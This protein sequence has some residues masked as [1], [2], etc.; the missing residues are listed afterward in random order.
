MRTCQ[1]VKVRVLV[2][3]DEASLREGLVDLLEGDGHRV[4][5]TADGR[6]AVEAL[7]GAGYAWRAER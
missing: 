2:V 7:D 3:E 4:T 1:N 5:A 6:R